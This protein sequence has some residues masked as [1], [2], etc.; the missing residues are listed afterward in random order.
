MGST[1]AIIPG[2]ITTAGQVTSVQFKVDPG[3]FTPAEGTRSSWGSTSPRIRPRRSSLRSSRSRPRRAGGRTGPSRLLQPG[4]RQGQQAGEPD[5]LGRPHDAPSPQGRPAAGGLHGQVEGASKTTGNFLLGFYLP[6]DATGAGTVTTTDIQTIISKLGN[7]STSSNYTFDADANRD[8]KISLVDGQIASSEPGCE[9]HGQPDRHRQ[10]RPGDRR[11]AE[12]P[13]HQLQDRPLHRHGHAEFL[14]HFR[15][16]QQ[17]LAGCDGH[18][19]C[20]GQLQHHGPARRRLQHVQRHHQGRV[21]PDDQ[22]S[23]RAGDLHAPSAHGREHA[24]ADHHAPR[25]PRRRL[26]DR[27]AEGST[28][29]RI[30][31]GQH[32]PV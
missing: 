20:L 22:R 25:R 26:R 11:S 14:R 15:R 27:Q 8:G 30:A 2:T 4:A 10:S 16:G 29:R 21:R 19:R 32:W 17:Q 13:H 5:E 12:H 7:A 31:P 9:D 28:A 6:G 1:F 3:Q 23:D 24:L 18:D